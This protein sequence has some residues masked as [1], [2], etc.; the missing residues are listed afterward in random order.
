VAQRLPQRG[1]GPRA[2]RGRRQAVPRAAAALGHRRH[3]GPAGREPGVHPRPRPDAAGVRPDD[4]ASAGST[5]GARS[6]TC[7]PR[8]PSC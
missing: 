2:R 3:A 1:A 7:W 8:W 5:R 4:A 6:A